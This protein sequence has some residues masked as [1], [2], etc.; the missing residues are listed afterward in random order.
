[1][2]AK[3][4]R[5]PQAVLTCLGIIL[6]LWAGAGCTTQ[7]IV[8]DVRVLSLPNPKSTKTVKIASVTDSRSFLVDPTYTPG[9]RE[10][11]MSAIQKD[12]ADIRSR[13]VA[14]ENYINARRLFLLPPGETVAGLVREVLANALRAEGYRVLQTGDAGYAQAKPINAEITQFWAWEKPA[15]M[16]MTKIESEIITKIEGAILGLR[17]GPTIRAYT[18]EHYGSNNVEWNDHSYPLILD[19]GLDEFA[20]QLKT[21]LQAPAPTPAPQASVRPSSPAPGANTPVGRL[22]QLKSAHGRGLITDEEYEKKRKIILET[23]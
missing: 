7:S 18:T 23:M 11:C 22:E 6:A 9:R 4:N 20:Q 14:R 3:R 2:T 19:R 5:S 8:L 15:G 16:W 1:M 10:P 13:A 21:V 12:S 17:D